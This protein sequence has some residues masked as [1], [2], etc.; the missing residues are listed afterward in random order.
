MVKM[1]QAPLGRSE[2]ERALGARESR[3]QG[4]AL[5]EFGLILPILL[6]IFLG[7]MDLSRAFYAGVIA[8]HAAREGA[9]YAMGAE[10]G[11]NIL[12]D[13]TQTCSAAPPLTCTYVKDQVKNSLG[14]CT[15]CPD[16]LALST[17]LPDVHVGGY[18]NDSGGTKFGY[19]DGSFAA[20]PPAD[21]VCPS[22]CTGGQVQVEVSWDMPLWTG[23]LWERFGVKTLHI[24]GYAAATMF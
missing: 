15:G 18:Q 6:V 9:R 1:R 4:Q 22:F 3:R 2:G 7:L 19:A 8:E 21:A 17:G 13:S 16:Y 20:G 24:R 14:N 5:V 10:P 12:V 23:F 11:T